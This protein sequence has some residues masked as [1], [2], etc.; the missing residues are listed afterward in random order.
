[1]ITDRAYQMLG[2]ICRTTGKFKLHSVY[3]TLY[4]ALVRSQLEY[5]SAVWNPYYEVYKGNLESVQRKLSKMVFHRLKLEQCPYETRLSYHKLPTLDVRRFL[6]G[7]MT[8][9]NICLS[10]V[11][12]PDLLA[13]IDFWVPRPGCLMCLHNLNVV[14]TRVGEPHWSDCA[15]IL[16]V[17]LVAVIFIVLAGMLS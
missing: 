6:L 17:I 11:D 9:R 2:F 8:L 5:G 13:Q 1:M 16:I 12:C 3:L 7:A 15:A 14:L 10:E 4:R